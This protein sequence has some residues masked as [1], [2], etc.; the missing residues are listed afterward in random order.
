MGS[1]LPGGRLDEAPSGAGSLHIP[2]PLVGQQ[3]EGDSNHPLGVPA[4][5]ALVRGG[6]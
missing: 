2:S 4:S 3:V 6:G 5:W 1:K